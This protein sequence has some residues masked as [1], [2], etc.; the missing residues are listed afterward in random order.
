MTT[1]KTWIARGS[2]LLCAL[3]AS[4]ALAQAPVIDLG[5]AGTP[6][7]AGAGAERGG[8]GELLHQVQAL[9]QEVMMLRGEVEQQGHELEQLRQQSLDR[10]I[11][12]DR[13]IGGEGGERGGEARS[14]GAAAPLVAPVPVPEPPSTSGSRRA[15]AGEHEDYK[16]AYARV[17]GQEFSAAITAF[18]RFLERHPEGRYAPNAH[19]WLG[20]LYLVQ[21]PPQP[22]EAEA[23]FTRLLRD[24]PDNAKVPDAMFKLGRIYYQRGEQDRARQVLEQV[25]AE[26][27]QQDTAAVGLARQFIDENF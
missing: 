10:Y 3:T 11:D 25:I 27:R 8:V 24:Y 1:G 5:G 6:P 23:A 14:E 20:E 2:A 21:S 9:Q 19:Y 7:E 12:L 16:A 13:R 4:L 26:Y 22:E 17:K 15:Q 18:K